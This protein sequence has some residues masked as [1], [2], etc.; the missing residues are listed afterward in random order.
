MSRE[1]QT[2]KEL[3]A[4]PRKFQ[5]LWNRVTQ[6]PAEMRSKGV[7]LSEASTRFG[8]S[9]N[10]V[11][12]LIPSAFRKDRNGRYEVKSTD[13]LLRVLLIPSNKGLREVVVR[14]SREASIV[15]IYW[16]AVETYLKRGD[17]SALRK[18]NRRTVT[19]A[20]GER[21]RLLTNLEELERQASAGVFDFESIYGRTR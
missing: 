4:K 13:D 2:V 15:G 21:I 20:N 14:G 18:L 16:N 7:S 17:A 6:I 19:D 1:P 5:A 11:L 10:T 12:D 8:V 3:F 9:P